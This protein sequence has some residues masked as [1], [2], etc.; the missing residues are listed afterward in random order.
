MLSTFSLIF[1][2]EVTIAKYPF[3]SAASVPAFD[4][5]YAAMGGIVVACLVVVVVV[6]VV[7]VLLKNIVS[8]LSQMD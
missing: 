7:A 1:I 3:F 2:L 4:V 8:S 6:V 5:T